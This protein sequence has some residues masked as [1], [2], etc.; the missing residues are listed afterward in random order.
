MNLSIPPV[1][2]ASWPVA[3]GGVPSGS[4]CRWLKPQP[5]SQLNASGIV[6]RSH[7]SKRR[8]GRQ[9]VRS[10]AAG[11]VAGE[12]VAVIQGIEGFGH[13]FH[14]P[15]LAER[16]GAADA[17][18]QA[19]EIVARAHVAADEIPVHH[20][21]SGGPLDGGGAGSNV[22]WQGRVILQHPAHL[23]AV[24]VYRAIEDHAVALIVVAR[25]VVPPDIGVVDRRT[26]ETRTARLTACWATCPNRQFT[27]GTPFSSPDQPGLSRH[28]D[29]KGAVFSE[30]QVNSRR[31]TASTG[32]DRREGAAC[33]RRIRRSCNRRALRTACAR[34]RRG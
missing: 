4:A 12:V 27:W 25:S 20:R 21:P 24:T 23:E 30:P 8:R 14:S 10:G 15:A 22:P 34:V 17:R 31:T 18:T 29:R 2:Q 3:V 16:E 26:K 11:S 33:R 7:L 32:R 19:E 6:D 5:R 1:R 13:Y 28:T 9:R